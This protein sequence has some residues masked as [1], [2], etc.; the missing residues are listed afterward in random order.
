[1]AGTSEEYDQLKSTLSGT[2]EGQQLFEASVVR[3]DDEATAYPAR[4]RLNADKRCSFLQKDDLC[5][6]HAQHGE[7]SLWGV[8]SQYPR[9]LTAFGNS[10]EMAGLSSCPEVARQLLLHDDAMDVV[11]LDE[12]TLTRK[13]PH[14]EYHS[15]DDQLLFRHYNEI[16]SFLLELLKTP[17]S[18][19]EEG[20]FFAV[21][22]AKQAS[23]LLNGDNDSGARK[24]LR[25]LYSL[26]EKEGLLGELSAQYAA[27]EVPKG[28]AF[29]VANALLVTNHQT[30]IS[31]RMKRLSEQVNQ[32]YCEP[33]TG[34][35]LQG[36]AILTRY[37][38]YREAIN[39]RA[40]DRVNRYFTHLAANFLFTIPFDKADTLLLYMQRMLLQLTIQKIL[41]FGHPEL[42]TALYSANDRQFHEELDRVIVEVTHTTNR[43]L[44]HSNLIAE[45][46]QTIASEEM[47]TFVVTLSLL[48][49]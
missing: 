13:Q 12:Q 4:I 40:H 2:Q 24:G 44:D 22:F 25:Q 30:E 1:V 31:P 8:C 29:L 49:F 21:F 18:S 35:P 38:G 46:Q 39:T 5:Q 19:L 17:Q 36:E 14:R 47:E 28:P 26:M 33:D 20:L 10:L 45:L 6:L 23:P 11:A 9:R 37:L 27:L 48:R 3:L 43:L 42:L 7:K 16:R 41:L 32:S 15:D 34:L